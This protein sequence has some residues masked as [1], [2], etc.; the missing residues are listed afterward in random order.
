MRQDILSG[1]MLTPS[2]NGLFEVPD[3]KATLKTFIRGISRLGLL[4]QLNRATTAG[5]KIFRHYC[6]YPAIWEENTFASWAKKADALFGR[7]IPSG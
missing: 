7:I 4:L 2:I 5:K 3:I 6:R 1:E